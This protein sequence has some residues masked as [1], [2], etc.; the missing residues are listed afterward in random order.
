[1]SLEVW[2]LSPVNVLIAMDL[3]QYKKR[4]I[5]FFDDRILETDSD[6]DILFDDGYFQAEY[7]E[8]S[9]ARVDWGMSENSS[10]VHPVCFAKCLKRWR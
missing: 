8:R 4:R 10:S 2:N 1:M 5:D 6:D 3:L 9:D 7:S